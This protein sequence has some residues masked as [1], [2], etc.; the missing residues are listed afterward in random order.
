MIFM[1]LFYSDEQTIARM[2]GADR[3]GLVE[4]HVTYNEVLRKR[5]RVLATR[6]LDP[7]SRSVTVRTDNGAPVVLPGPA[8]RTEHALSG[9]Y[10]VECADLDEAIELA[11]LYGMPEGLGS[12]EV[13]PVLGGWDYEP[14]VDTTAPP[15]AVW[16]RYADVSTWPE[17]KFDVAGASLDGPFRAGATGTLK[18]A[19][20]DAMPLRIVRATENEGYLSET[21]LAGSTLRIE[22]ILEPLPGGGT[23][24][25]H[26][27]T[28]PRAILDALGDEFGPVLYEGMR[29]TLDALAKAALDESAAP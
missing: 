13:R 23:R 2:E 20:R 26:R 25:T 10:L 22:H 8:V 16:R 1:F 29:Q 9:F 5:A 12:I 21:D 15:A 6:G 27:A 18:P 14:S 11:K 28:V 24:I 17:W 19:T 7:T 3:N 4:R